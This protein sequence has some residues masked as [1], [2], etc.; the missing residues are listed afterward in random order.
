MCK[1]ASKNEKKTE[2]G[3]KKCIFNSNFN[4]ITSCWL[5]WACNYHFEYI[6]KSE[7]TVEKARGEIDLRWRQRKVLSAID[8]ENSHNLAVVCII[9]ICLEENLFTVI[10]KKVALR[11]FTLPFL[12]GI[13]CHSLWT[14]YNR[15]FLLAGGKGGWIPTCHQTNACL[16]FLCSPQND[17]F[18][19]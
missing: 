1:S 14:S 9:I 12:N 10:G 13:A 6:V 8:C 2:T 18:K 17:T 11:W 4:D 7:H 19:S 3:S 16:L 5:A 15:V